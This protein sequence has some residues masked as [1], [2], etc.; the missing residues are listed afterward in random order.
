MALRME[1]SKSNS[2]DRIY[3]L[4]LASVHPS[5]LFY[6]LNSACANEKSTLLDVKSLAE[7]LGTNIDILQK[8]PG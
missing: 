5:P 4:V 8:D 3:L 1:V 2:E 6:L 7:E